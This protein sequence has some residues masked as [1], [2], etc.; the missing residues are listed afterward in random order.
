MEASAHSFNPSF[1]VV[2]TLPSIRSSAGNSLGS[3]TTTH[4]T[5]FFPAFS[6][7][8]RLCPCPTV[9][10]L[11]K[12]ILFQIP[13]QISPFRTPPHCSLIAPIPGNPILL[14]RL[15][16]IVTS[17]PIR[18]ERCAT[19]PQVMRYD[20][21]PTQVLWWSPAIPSTSCPAVAG[22]ACE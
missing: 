22:P 15:N 2:R 13:L 3:S 6:T 1:N 20:Y 12:V 21:N 4:P 16:C 18:I 8:S 5:S 17:H 11:R 7:P 19:H 9:S 10:Q 14:S